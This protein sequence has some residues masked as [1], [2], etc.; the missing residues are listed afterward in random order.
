MSS[1]CGVLERIG[2]NQ[3]ERSR[4]ISDSIMSKSIVDIFSSLQ[5]SVNKSS[6]VVWG[7]SV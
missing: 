6:V 1:L 7:M 4:I 2:V 3:L 5:S